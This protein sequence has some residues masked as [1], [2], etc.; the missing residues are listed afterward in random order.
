[1]RSGAGWRIGGILV[2]AVWLGPATAAVYKC[3]LPGGKYEYRG[4]P[5]Q[6][7]EGERLE[8][9]GASASEA[10]A[11]DKPSANSLQGTWC[12]FGV[13]A[14]EE[15]AIDSSAQAEWSFI[16][17]TLRYKLKAAPKPGPDIPLR[18]DG[19][20]FFLSDPLFGGGERAWTV[21]AR[22]NG[23]IVVKGPLGGYYHFRPGGC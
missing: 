21:L 23:M 16:G 1:M 8:V 17:D 14:S 9:G 18:R 7:G 19:Q 20:D 15:S 12:E 2:L 4:M 10:G 5:C 6:A 11:G 3:P 13:S 22:R